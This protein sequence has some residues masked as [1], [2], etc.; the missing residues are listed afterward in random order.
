MQVNVKKEE[1]PNFFEENEWGGK[2]SKSFWGIDAA[3]FYYSYLDREPYYTL[4]SSSLTS[5]NFKE[6]HSKIQSSGLSL[7]KTLNDDFV[8]RSDVVYTQDKVINSSTGLNL[9]NSK[10]DVLNYLVSLD[11]PT[12]NSWSAMFMFAVSDLQ[13]VPTGSFREDIQNYG[14]TKLTYDLGEEKSFDLSYTH[15]FN[16][17][18]HSVQSQLLLPLNSSFEFSVGGEFYWGRKTSTLSAYKNIS[19]VFISLKNY[20]QLL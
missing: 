14:L 18:G 7:A 8:F 1:G 16:K 15:E 13:T 12:Y 19:N 17:G 9:S 2:L 11:T 20:F 10:S 3:I 5:V 6:H 4:T